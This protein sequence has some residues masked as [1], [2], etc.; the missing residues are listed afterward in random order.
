MYKERILFE[1]SKGTCW[2][3]QL[4]PYTY[5]ETEM[6]FVQSWNLKFSQI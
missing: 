4:I 3:L 1:I 5:I 6:S 2:S